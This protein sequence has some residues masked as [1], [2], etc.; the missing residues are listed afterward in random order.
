MHVDDVDDE[1]SA[2]IKESYL[3]KKIKEKIKAEGEKGSQ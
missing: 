1:D 2:D 3:S